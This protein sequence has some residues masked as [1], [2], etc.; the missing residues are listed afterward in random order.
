MKQLDQLITA[1][2]GRQARGLELIPSENYASPKV[3]RALGTVYTNKYAEGYP[4]RRYYGGQEY[5]DQAE[6]WAPIL[7][8]VI[9]VIPFWRWT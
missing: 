6:S 1:E 9:Q 4:G 7:P 3:R 2:E 5:T 8:G